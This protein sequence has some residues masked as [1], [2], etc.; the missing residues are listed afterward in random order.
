M[1]SKIGLIVLAFLAGFIPFAGGCSGGDDEGKGGGQ[2]CDSSQQGYVT[3]GYVTCQPGTYCFSPAG[4]TCSDGCKS[5]ANCGCG[6]VCT[7]GSCVAN[8]VCGDGKCNGSESAASCPA[9]CGKCGDG[10]CGA[11]E[12]SQ[13]CPGDCPPSVCGNGVCEPGETNQT[14]ASDCQNAQKLK[15]HDN[16]DSY[17][18]FMCFKPGDL[19]ICYNACDAATDA[20]LKQF[21]SCAG[22]A[23]VSCDLSCF[24]YL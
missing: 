7:G 5:N 15:C 8:S 3:C 20:Q 1:R 17:N 6:E 14:C 11:G 18:F 4:A 2:S 21:N 12:T 16:C 13:S 9:D 24:D 10:A 23:S 19:Q 22:A